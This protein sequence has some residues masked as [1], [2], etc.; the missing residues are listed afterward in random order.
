MFDLQKKFQ[1]WVNVELSIKPTEQTQNLTSSSQVS[2][3][4]ALKSMSSKNSRLFYTGYC[5]EKLR[6]FLVTL[7][8]DDDLD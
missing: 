2:G 8:P 3:E 4:N 7:S 1:S 6:E 5:T